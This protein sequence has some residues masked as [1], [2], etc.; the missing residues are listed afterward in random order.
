[1]KKVSDGLSI[2]AIIALNDSLSGERSNFDNL[3]QDVAE[4][5]NPLKSNITS[6]ETAG[7][8]RRTNLTDSTAIRA[9]DD[10]ASMLLGYMCRP[11]EQWFKMQSVNLALQNDE[12]VSMYFNE[13]ERAILKNMYLSNF[14]MEIHED[15]LD[16]G[17]FG[18]SNMYIEKG[19]E[20]PLRFKNIKI[21]TYNIEE[22]AYG[23]I[24][25]VIYS[26]K[27]TAKQAVQRFGID[28]VSDKIKE[29]YDAPTK[30]S[31]SRKFKFIHAVMP[32]RKVDE[33][34]KDG[35]GMPFGSYYIDVA[36]KELIS[37]SGYMD[38]PYVVSRFL[39]DPDEIWGRSPGINCLA[40][41]KMV[42]AM[43]ATLIRSA[44]KKCDPVMMVADNSIM[45]QPSFDAGGLLFVRGSMFQD[46]PVALDTGADVGI[47][48]EMIKQEQQIIREAF[49]NDLADVLMDNKYM[50]ATEAEIR[51]NGK[52]LLAAAKMGRVQAEKLSKVIQRC[53]LLLE[54]QGLLPELPDV[55]KQNPNYEVSFTGKMALAMKTID[56]MATSMTLGMVEG[57]AQIDPTVLDN[58]NFNEIIRGNAISNGM[59]LKYINSQ[60]EVDGIRQGRAAQQEQ[61]NEMAMAQQGADVVNKLQKPTDQDSPLAQLT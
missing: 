55:L 1:M 58:F 25:T 23:M 9:N 20:Y 35:L 28:N 11:D 14:A 19:D 38:M 41:I 32:R 30:T 24:D 46:R 31:V 10:F 53:Y 12:E 44:E 54:D 59:Q 8:K 33:K 49:Y 43:K 39:K 6:K 47:T 17:C 3:W 13:V 36:E 15:F 22:S 42:N 21:S 61:M 50:T 5:C 57:L 4:F 7:R 52:Q 45:N 60:E 51:K 16:M 37:E 34:R 29:V 18:T 26:F 48:L 40:E 56:S 27:F 2:D